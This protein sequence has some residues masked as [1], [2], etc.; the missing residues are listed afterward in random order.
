M[1]PDINGK[2]M[3]YLLYLLLLSAYLSA[4]Q[5]PLQ[6]PPTEL[7]LE[8]ALRLT[9]QHSPDLRV[10]LANA[11]AAEAAIGSSRAGLYPQVTANGSYTHIA[12]TGF[13]EFPGGQGLVR[14]SFVAPNNYNANL[15][16]SYTIFDFGRTKTGIALAENGKQLVE[17]SRELTRQELALATIQSFYRIHFVQQ[18]IGVQ[19]RQLAALQQTLQ[20]TEELRANGEATGFEV[21][22]TQVRIAT[23]ENARADLEN[24]LDV[25]L[26]QLERLTGLDDLAGTELTNEW[27][28]TTVTPT[29]FGESSVNRAEVALARLRG[30]GAALRE[31][32]AQQ[33]SKPIISANVAAGYKNQILPD[34]QELRPN[35]VAAAQ[36]TVPLFT[37]YRNRYGV[38]EARAR[39][40]AAALELTGTQEQVDAEVR[41]AQTTL[42]TSFEKI[43]RSRLQVEQANQAADLARLKYKNGVITNLD[44]L[45]SEVSV[46]QAEIAQLNT[47]FEYTLN[48]YQLKR[49]LGQPLYPTN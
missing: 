47:I 11:A 39:S 10:S 44:L 4:Q 2:Q 1:P 35:Y 29:A 31:T 3:K 17:T 12:P 42:N 33:G 16:F 25:T 18:A 9:L 27:V 36:V 20:E 22:S 41:Q 14:N 15:N 6:P 23:V 32:L 34:I 45:D 37:G 46:A 26:I 48:T 8:E 38:Q 30:E 21:L 7:G 28:D 49:V 24:Q 19:N 5:A 43:A 40:E 13:V